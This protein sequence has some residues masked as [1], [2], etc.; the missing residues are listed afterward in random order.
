[1]E[2]ADS[3]RDRIVSFLRDRLEEARSKVLVFAGYPGATEWIAAE[4]RCEFQ[5]G[6][7]EFRHDLNQQDKEDFVR[8]F[9]NNPNVWI[10]VSDETGGEGRNFQFVD[11]ILHVDTPWSVALIE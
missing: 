8:E 6:V 11:E 4:L 2:H 10:L 7:R 9:Q 3:R 5:D 1:A